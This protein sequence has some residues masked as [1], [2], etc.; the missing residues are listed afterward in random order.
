MA[1]RFPRFP[2]S[3]AIDDLAS[4]VIALQSQLE[5][6]NSTIAKLEARTPGYGMSVVIPKATLD[7]H[8]MDPAVPSIHDPISLPLSGV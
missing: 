8:S 6:A 7:D 5:V 3:A 1:P 4:Q 2:A